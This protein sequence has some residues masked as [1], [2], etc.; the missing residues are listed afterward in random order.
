MANPPQATCIPLHHKGSALPEATQVASEAIVSSGDAAV[1]QRA[2]KRRSPSPSA[3]PD[4]RPNPRFAEREFDSGSE[5]DAESESTHDA[6]AGTAEGHSPV[7]SEH[8]DDS[9][10]SL[11]SD[12]R[13][14]S[15]KMYVRSECPAVK[16]KG[17][18]KLMK[19]RKRISLAE[20]LA[21]AKA[22]KAEGA[23]PSK[24]R[25]TSISPLREEKETG[26]SNR[27]LFGSSDEEDE[28]EEGAIPEPRKITN[29]LD[30]RQEDF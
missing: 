5:N 30:Q 14:H 25:T 11:A 27:N 15:P 4:N 18:P 8:K 10:L 20:G 2:S 28:E 12:H 7:P 29:D 1:G 9:G 6:P 17:T 26:Y 3:S 16:A 13:D 19:P 21:R 22:S 23:N 24:K